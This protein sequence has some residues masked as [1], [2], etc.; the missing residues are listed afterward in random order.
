V[1]AFDRRQHPGGDQRLED[2]QQKSFG[3]TPGLGD[4]M[5]GC[6]C[7]LLLRRH[8]DD[9]MKGVTGSTGQLHQYSAA[10]GSPGDLRSFGHR[11]W[12]KDTVR[13]CGA[14]TPISQGEERLCGFHLE[15]DWPERCSEGHYKAE[16]GSGN[17]SFSM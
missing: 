13:A 11:G 2:L 15:W 8:V 5:R 7:V 17:V 9:R 6:R 14:R 16:F 10:A 3:D 1:G 4:V 12:D